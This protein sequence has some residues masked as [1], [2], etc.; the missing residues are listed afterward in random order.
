MEELNDHLLKFQGTS[1]KEIDQVNLMNRVDTKFVFTKSQFLQF[2]PELKDFYNCLQID[3]DRI[4]SYQSLYFD[5]DSFTFF[6]DHHNQKNNRF[7]VRIRN[8][9]NSELFFLEVKHKQKKRTDKSRVKI[10]QFVEKLNESQLDF[11]ENVFGKHQ[12][13]RPV[14]KNQFDRVSLSGKEFP[15]RLTIDL[16]IKFEWGKHFSNYDNLV[17]AELKQSDLNRNSPFFQLMKKH[18]IRPFRISKYCI[19]LYLI[20]GQYI[21]KGN[22]FKN[23]VKILHQLNSKKH[24]LSDTLR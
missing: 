13:L 6:R 17:V 14:I 23:K 20:Y 24:E 7:K 8:Y 4:Q 11:V 15:E 21:N 19:G 22:R 1:L 12:T 18:Q 9:V 5:D 16:D 2:L 3:G 10:D